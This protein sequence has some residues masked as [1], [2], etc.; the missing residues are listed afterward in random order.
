MAEE[1]SQVFRGDGHMEDGEVARTQAKKSAPK[2]AVPAPAAPVVEQAPV[3]EAVVPEEVAALAPNPADQD[4]DFTVDKS[5]LWQM[6]DEMKVRVSQMASMS[7]S[8]NQQLDM[9]EKNLRK[10]QKKNR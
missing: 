3:E 4:L 5:T 7:A 6:S 9:Q 8:T 10:L 1:E 2:P